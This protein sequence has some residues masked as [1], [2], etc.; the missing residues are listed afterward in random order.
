MFYRLIRFFLR[1]L[2]P[3]LARWQVTGM[4]NV[5]VE[6]CLIIA[7][8]HLHFL[9]PVVLSAAMPRQI[10]FMAKAELFQTPILALLARLYGAFSVR[11]GEIDRHALRQ[12]TNVLEARQALGIF[13]EGTRSRSA[14]LQR[15]RDG[16][17]LIAL[18]ADA[19]ILPVAISGTE[20][21]FPA[22]KRL[23]RATV[24]VAIGEP[25]TL[26]SCE[27]QISRHQLSGLTDE[28]MRRIAELLPLEYRGFYRG[29]AAHPPVQQPSQ[30]KRLQGKGM[31]QVAEVAKTESVM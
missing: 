15:A 26:P 24:R 13:P 30:H 7:A 11:R 20:K 3:L 10:F 9:D 23:R 28:I 12:S 25:F 2:L 16:I 17:A 8:N 21:V 18:W 14:H 19:P 29:S 22:L 27:G 4:E 31:R 5:P 6:G 1:I